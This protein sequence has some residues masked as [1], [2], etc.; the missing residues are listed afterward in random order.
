MIKKWL[1]VVLLILNSITLFASDAFST[2]MINGKTYYDVSKE[3]GSWGVL[4]INFTDANITLNFSE[5][6]HESFLYTVVDSD[7][8]NA[9]EGILKVDD[10]DGSYLK[11]VDSNESSLKVAVGNSLEKVLNPQKFD[12]FFFDK[13]K[14]ETFAT[15]QNQNLLHISGDVTI[16]HNYNSSDTPPLRVSLIDTGDGNIIDASLTLKTSAESGDIYAYTAYISANHSYI[17]K[18]ETTDNIWKYFYNFGADHAL[19]GSDGNADSLIKDVNINWIQSNQGNNIPDQNQTGWVNISQN[20]VENVDIDLASLIQNSYKISGTISLPDA[21]KLGHVC[22]VDDVIKYGQDCDVQNSQDLGY[23]NLH[24][25]VLDKDGNLLSMTDAT[26]TDNTNKAFSY[27]TILDNV[28]DALLMRV[29]INKY[30]EQSEKNTHEDYYVGVE[31]NSIKLTPASSVNFDKNGKPSVD[32]SGSI[33]LSFFDSNKNATVDLDLDISKLFNLISVNIILPEGF[34]NGDVCQKADGS[35][36]VKNVCESDENYLGSNK[37]SFETI[38]TTNGS[39]SW[40]G[41]PISKGGKKVLAVEKNGKYI[42]RVDK[43]TYDISSQEAKWKSY[44]I[45][46]DSTHK[47]NSSTSLIPENKVTW[48]KVTWK[49]DNGN[50]VYLPDLNKTGYIEFDDSDSYNGNYDSETPLTIDFKTLAENTY[51]ISGTITPPEDFVDDQQHLLNIDIRDADTGNFVGWAEVKKDSNGDL[52]YTAEL[53]GAESGEKLVL[54]LNYST[55]QSFKSYAIDFTNNSFVDMQNISQK[56]NSEGIYVPD[57]S[58]DVKLTLGT[59][60]NIQK[61][62]NYTTFMTNFDNNKMAIKGTIKLSNTTT[63]G[64]SNDGYWNDI[65]IEAIDKTTGKFVASTHIDQGTGNSFDYELDFSKTGLYIIRVSKNIDGN[66]ESYYINFGNDHRPGGSGENKDTFI[67]DNNVKWKDNGEGVWIPD[68]AQTGYIKLT[69]KETATKD[70]DFKALEDSF[71]K[72]KGTIKVEDSFI[73]GDI[74]QDTSGDKKSCKDSDAILVGSKHLRVEAI[75]KVTGEWISSVDVQKDKNSDGTYSFDISLGTS[76]GA[77]KDKFIIRVVKEI[78]TPT[79]WEHNEAYI[80]FGDN[81]SFDDTDPLVS[82]KKVNWK[83]V[84]V[85]GQDLKNWMP[86]PAQTGWIETSQTVDNI[87]IDITTLGQNEKKISGTITFPSG[88]DLSSTN[89]WANIEIIDAKTGNWID[90]AQIATDDKYT[91]RVEPEENDNKYILRVNYSYYDPTTLENSFSRIKYIDFGNDKAFGGSDD[92]IKDESM[93]KWVEK[94]VDGQ[95]Y[96]NWVPDITNPL[97]VTDNITNANINLASEANNYHSISGTISKNS[98]DD[99]TF[100]NIEILATNPIDGTSK[101]VTLDSLGNFSLKELPKDKTYTLEVML[102]FADKHYHLFVKNNGSAKVDD[103]VLWGERTANDGTTYWGPKDDA[104]YITLTEDKNISITL[105]QLTDTRYSLD[106]K[107]SNMPA[108]TKTWLNLFVPNTPIYLS[109]EATSSDS[110]L[111]KTIDDIKSKNGYYLTLDIDGKGSY[112]YDYSDNGGKLVKN[113]QWVGKD[114]NGKTICPKSGGDDI[115]D[116][117]YSNILYWVPNVTPFNIDQNKTLNLSLPTLPKI[118]GTISGLSDIAGKKVSIYAYEMNSNGGGSDS[119]WSEATV[120]EN[121]E[122]SFELEV[123]G[124]NS[125]TYRVELWN[126]EIGGFVVSNSNNGTYNLMDQG[127]SWQQD[128]NSNIW[129]PVDST[130]LTVDSSS[131]L[132]LSTL[133]LPTLKQ[134]TITISGADSDENVWVDLEGIDNSNKGEWKGKSNYN[135]ATGSY[136][137]SITLKVSGGDYRVYVYPS[138]HDGG[139]GSDGDNDSNETLTEFTTFNWDIS[140]ADKVSLSSDN[141]TFT[142][143]LSPS[144]ASFGSLSGYIKDSDG[145][146]LSNC[147][148]GYVEAWSASKSISKTSSVD[149]SC[150]Y[151]FANLTVAND[152]EI[153]YFSNNSP[154]VIKADSVNITQGSSNTKNLQKSSELKNITGTISGEGNLKAALIEYDDSG[155][156]V[157]R[158]ADLASSNG[159]FAFDSVDTSDTSKNLAVAISKM[160]VDNDTGE[161]RVTLYN[162]KKLDG[163]SLSKEGIETDDSDSLTLTINNN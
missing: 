30:D 140:K 124:G 118:T 44:Y 75:N 15:S 152:Y 114:T 133:S 143:N 71:I 19:G 117:D 87:N 60:K 159:N 126:N 161:V 2:S 103:E 123:E 43:Q 141:N 146:N 23:N 9:T 85:S 97:T 104:Y 73:V 57:F 48:E 28:S 46:F 53:D 163:T 25:E 32:T 83:E 148:D 79:D 116:C 66:W 129:K 109:S 138:N 157:I 7:G 158:V 11:I 96:S 33:P 125:K 13:Q 136:A 107:V 130:L 70:I 6:E 132:N 120:N 155:F 17:L 18:V 49:D 112:A 91:L 105:P 64:M 102:D 122:L 41:E 93:V 139:V 58:D 21:L 127:K 16:T 77:D 29:G 78:N 121:G 86:N 47:I 50:D 65:S 115:W 88:F 111:D 4:D 3:D 144:D 10:E 56:Q 67:V 160:I 147:T 82:A 54:I 137:D 95:S 38:D 45:S 145:S 76:K 52:K 94:K 8:N 162:A 81:H 68:P 153:T 128:S 108:N 12:Y 72:L 84:S 51:K 40:L 26:S 142:I 90:S 92:T 20:S 100:S 150:Q 80:N 55:P 35:V 42:L 101:R 1:V 34:E 154:L 63:L 149:E 39:W 134:V 156:T 62:I 98:N 61:D 69:E 31:N 36:V 106:V 110:S 5:D 74:C 131:G 89:S 27:T 14:A 113:P 151:S 22:K 99:G 37:V 24:I 59:E 135:D 119:A